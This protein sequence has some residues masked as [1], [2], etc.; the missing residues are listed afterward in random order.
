MDL[1]KF[2]PFNKK[3]EK[4]EPVASSPYLRKTTRSH[5]QEAFS[6][7]RIILFISFSRLG[8]YHLSLF[9]PKAD[10]LKSITYSANKTLEFSLSFVNY[11]VFA[12]FICCLALFLLFY[13]IRP[14]GLRP[15]IG[16]KGKWLIAR[17]ILDLFG[18]LAFVVFDIFLD[19]F[20]LSRDITILFTSLC[21]CTYLFLIYKLYREQRTY[22]NL[23]FWEIFRFALVGLVASVFDF[24][25]TRL[26]QF[27]VFKGSTAGYVTG[28]S[29]AMGFAVGVVINY[30]R[31]TFMVYKAAKSNFSKSWIG[32]VYFL[33]LAIVGLFIGI[34]LQ[35]FFYDYLN[36]TKGISFLSYPVCFVIRTLIVMVFNYITRKILIY[37]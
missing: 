37:R 17:I 24:L 7:I 30:L 11:S 8:L 22:S 13:L 20:G 35:Y 3:D 9:S 31:S 19:G 18:V 15:K 28:L 6:T 12:G 29:T 1:Q 32:I 4:K 26:F 23:L 25:T 36:L 21:V 16:E 2:N 10:D 33:G 27:S 34:G 14:S 5:V